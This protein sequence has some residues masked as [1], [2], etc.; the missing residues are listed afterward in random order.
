MLSATRMLIADRNQQANNS[1]DHVAVRRMGSGTFDSDGLRPNTSYDLAFSLNQQD[2][3]QL[4][5]AGW[6]VLPFDRANRSTHIIHHWWNMHIDTEEHIDTTFKHAIGDD[7][8]FD[9]SLTH[10]I[11]QRVRYH[12]NK[13][14]CSSL[15]LRDGAYTAID[16]DDDGDIK[17]RPITALSFSQLCPSIA[18]AIAIPFRHHQ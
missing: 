7:Y 1:A 4:V 9:K 12:L 2:P 3:K 10:N 14:V 11:Y 15:I 16:L 8:V 18:D 17:E 5:V 13:P 6:L